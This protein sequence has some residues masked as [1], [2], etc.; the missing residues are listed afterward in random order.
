M[1]GGA[2]EVDD[3]IEKLKYIM[4]R[5]NDDINTPENQEYLQRKRDTFST[6]IEHPKYII[7]DFESDVHTLTHLPNHVDVDTI[8]I[9][10][11]HDYEDCK[12]GGFT[13]SG[14]DVVGKFC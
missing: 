3:H 2:D 4:E 9:G 6:R 11:T 5:N 13:Y 12:T 10:N 7:Y 1:K 14:Y 8:T